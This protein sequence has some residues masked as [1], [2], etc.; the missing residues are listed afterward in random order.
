MVEG[1]LTKHEALG[2]IPSTEKKIQFYILILYLSNSMI[3]K[4]FYAPSSP[5]SMLQ[6]C[7]G[8]VLFL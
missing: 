6:L 8:Q 1:L 2:S 5:H 3:D 7:L 4:A